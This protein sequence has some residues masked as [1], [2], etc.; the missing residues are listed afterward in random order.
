[1]VTQKIGIIGYRKIKEIIIESLLTSST[2]IGIFKYVRGF[3]N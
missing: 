3:K 2:R 1:M